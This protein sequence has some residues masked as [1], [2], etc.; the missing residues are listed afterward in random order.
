MLDNFF[1]EKQDIFQNQPQ[2]Q[3]AMMQQR[4]P[5]QQQQESFQSMEQ[6][7][8]RMQKPRGGHPME[9]NIPMM[10][11]GRNMNMMMQPNLEYQHYQQ[12]QQQ[13]QPQ[14]GMNMSRS[15][16]PMKTSNT[17]MRRE[18]GPNEMLGPIGGGQSLTRKETYKIK[19]KGAESSG[20]EVRDVSRK[21]INETQ[22]ARNQFGVGP[23]NLSGAMLDEG[24]NGEDVE[25]QF[26][27]EEIPKKRMQAGSSINGLLDHPYGGSQPQ[28]A[29]GYDNMQPQ[30]QQ[31][32]QYYN[33]Q[34]SQQMQ[35][36]SG[37]GQP[38][39]QMQHPQ[40]FQ[41]YQQ[42]QQQPNQQPF[43][44]QQAMP[45]QHPQQMRGYLPGPFPQQQQGNPPE[46]YRQP[47]YNEPMHPEFS[48]SRQP[49]KDG[50]DRKHGFDFRNEDHR[51]QQPN[52]RIFDS[53]T[54][55]ILDLVGRKQEKI[56]SA[57]LTNTGM[58]HHHHP[59]SSGGKSDHHHHHHHGPRLH[60]EHSGPHHKEPVPVLRIMLTKL[61]ND[62]PKY[63]EDRYKKG[64][65]IEQ[66]H[67]N[68]II[69]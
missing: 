7:Q 68:A 46:F 39:L 19:K 14:R 2:D 66:L 17:G 59:L 25:G 35:S 36:M 31:L 12:Q 62:L 18:P 44:Q 48:G 21:K 26:S 69:Q 37:Q 6:Q 34:G 8:Q 16:E 49:V 47:M 9:K 20:D 40:Q 28:Y 53:K 63:Y 32:G 64:K 1:R 3:Q 56:Q 23:S 43:Q 38:Q 30:Q 15:M 41:Q 65:L 27:D 42:Y 5:R 11:Q 60:R 33:F 4:A 24:Q 54:Q 57:N 13:Q 29:G 58:D 51:M 67:I 50:H 10:E 55:Q 22:Y 45:I 52:N 61:K